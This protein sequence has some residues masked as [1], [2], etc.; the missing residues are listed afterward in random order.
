MESEVT[1][2]IDGVE[3]GA[4]ALVGRDGEV[5]RVAGWGGVRAGMAEETG[6]RVEVGS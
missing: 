3:A 5:E 2:G 4:M 6:V 1:K